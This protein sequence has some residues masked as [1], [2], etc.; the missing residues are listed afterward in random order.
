MDDKKQRRVGV[1]TWISYFNFGTYLQ[2][3]A[4][5]TVVRSLGYACSIVSD[6]KMVRAL[7]K[8]SCWLRKVDL[9][10]SQEG[11][12]LFYIWHASDRGGVCLI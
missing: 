1:I 8:E 11:R 6:E 12:C 4:L 3:Y 9:S 10:F 5:Q 7:R 2:A